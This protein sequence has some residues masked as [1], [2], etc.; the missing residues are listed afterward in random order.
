MKIWSPVCNDLQKIPSIPSSQDFLKTRINKS[1][2]PATRPSGEIVPLDVTLPII[3]L[4]KTSYEVSEKN[5]KN[6]PPSKMSIQRS[7]NVFKNTLFPCQIMHHNENGCL[8]ASSRC[9]RLMVKKEKKS[10]RPILFIRKSDLKSA[11]QSNCRAQIKYDKVT[12]GCTE[13]IKLMK[14]W[15]SNFKYLVFVEKCMQLNVDLMQS[16]LLDLRISK[17]PAFLISQLDQ[18]V[19]KLN[20]KHLR[21]RPWWSYYSYVCEHLLVIRIKSL[22]TSSM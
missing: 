16:K 20:I 5:I 21:K 19:T 15:C 14:F 17:H 18:Q 11:T 9:S 10:W 7:R 6:L 3:Y 1:L 12:L 4:Q 22:N 8:L 13:N 2:Y